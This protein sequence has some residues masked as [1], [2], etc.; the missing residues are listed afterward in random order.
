MRR[1]QPAIRLAQEMG[2]RLGEREVLLRALSQHTTPISLRAEIDAAMSILRIIPGDQLSFDMTALADL[3]PGR[4]IVLMMEVEEENTTSGTP[5][6]RSCWCYQQ[7]HFANALRH[8][9]VTDDYLKLD[10]PDS[11]GSVTAEAQPW[12]R[13]I[14]RVALP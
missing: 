12:S 5:G 11:T 10:A 2:A 4:D 7:C 13:G 8:R 6:R 14:A 9:E 1:L 3:D